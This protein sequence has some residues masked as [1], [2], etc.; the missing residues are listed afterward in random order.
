MAGDYL[1]E[2]HQDISEF[3]E[4]HI[5]DEEERQGF[6]DELMKRKGYLQQSHWAPPAPQDGGQQKPGLLRPGAGGKG[7]AAGTSKRQ[8]SYFRP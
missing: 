6:V 2:I 3:A 8:G 1:D 4:R 5:E 7:K